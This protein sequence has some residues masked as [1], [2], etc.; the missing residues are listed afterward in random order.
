MEGWIDLK[1]MWMDEGWTDEWMG[2]GGLG[3]CVDGR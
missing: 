3:A 1:G 2:E